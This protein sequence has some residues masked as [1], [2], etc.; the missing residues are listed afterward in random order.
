MAVFPDNKP[1]NVNQAHRPQM[2]KQG[3]DNHHCSPSPSWPIA[4]QFRG[5]CAYISPNAPSLMPIKNQDLCPKGLSHHA[6]LSVGRTYRDLLPE[7]SAGSAILSLS[8]KIANAG[9]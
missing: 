5:K 8:D 3:T 4:Q 7:A 1:G 9:V 2:S 6:Y